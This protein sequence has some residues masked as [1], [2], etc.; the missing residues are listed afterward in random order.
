MRRSFTKNREIIPELDAFLKEFQEFQISDGLINFLEFSPHKNSHKISQKII[1]HL[2]KDTCHTGSSLD[3][4][5]N[6]SS[7]QCHLKNSNVI[8]FSILIESSI[9]SKILTNS[10]N[11]TIFLKIALSANTVI[12]CRVSPLQKSLIIQQVKNYDKKA[13]TL[14]IG[15]GENDVSMILEAHIGIGIYGE[16]RMR[17]IILLVSFNF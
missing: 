3:F 16:E 13:V 8:P 14:A 7:S 9:L 2:F 5:L 6:I 17:A 1:Q 12:C 10:Q 15:D 11:A 4:Q